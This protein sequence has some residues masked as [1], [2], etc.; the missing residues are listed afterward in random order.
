MGTR[1]AD[2]PYLEATLPKQRPDGFGAE[3]GQMLRD[4]VKVPEFTG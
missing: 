1:V 4:I 3:K 2:F